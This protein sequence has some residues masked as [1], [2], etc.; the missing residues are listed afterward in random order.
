MTAKARKGFTIWTTVLSVAFA[1]LLFPS[2]VGRHGVV[3]SLIYTGLGISVIWLAYFGIG[4]FI[5]W[6]VTKELKRKSQE[7][8]GGKERI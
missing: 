3:M 5:D 7:G 2:I 4:H 6:A 1:L 8:E